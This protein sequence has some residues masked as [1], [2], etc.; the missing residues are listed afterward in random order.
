MQYHTLL[1]R[2]ASLEK[3]LPMIDSAKYQSSMKLLADMA[4]KSALAEYRL[5]QMLPNELLSDLKDY[6]AVMSSF[7]KGYA[8]YL[9]LL[10]KY[11]T[12]DNVTPIATFP[13]IHTTAQ[14]TDTAQMQKDSARM[15]QLASQ[16]KAAAS[17][18][19]GKEDALID[20]MK[21]AV[22]DFNRI[23][24]LNKKLRE[25]LQQLAGDMDSVYDSGFLSGN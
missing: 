21:D 6:G 5:T 13:G 7:Y 11:Q 8:S 23:L 16:V 17:S 10:N 14:M 12:N 25:G 15:D 20:D 9:Q 2:I 24:E 3:E 1:T 22:K 4:K 18:L 19:E